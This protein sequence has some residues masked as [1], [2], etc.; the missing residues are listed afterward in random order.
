M[1]KR[2]SPQLDG[3]ARAD[4]L[5]QRRRSDVETPLRQWLGD[6]QLTDEE[7]LELVCVDILART[8]PAL[9][10]D[11]AAYFSDFPALADDPEAVLD[12]IDADI[13]ARRD[14]QLAIQ[15]EDY[16][17]RFPA[18]AARIARLIEI[19]TLESCWDDGT[20]F[21]FDQIGG[22]AQ[23]GGELSGDGAGSDG[24]SGDFSRYCS[25]EL[26]AD[27]RI[28]GLLALRDEVSCL[29]GSSAGNRSVVIKVVSKRRL[30]NDAL[31]AR[32]GD[33]LQRLSG[34]SHP[35][36]ISPDVIAE[37][38]S[39][40]VM[41]RPWVAGT[42]FTNRYLHNSPPRAE[43]SSAA[44]PL[45]LSPLLRELADLGY[46]LAAVH[47][48]GLAH[49]AVHP[50]NLLRDHTGSLRIVDAGFGFPDPGLQWDWQ[51]P[52]APLV[53]AVDA[54]HHA[55]QVHDAASLR[56][57]VA[58]ALVPYVGAGEAPLD[59]PLDTPLHQLIRWCEGTSQ[60]ARPK[61][62]VSQIADNLL[63]LADG[64]PLKL[65]AGAETA[66]RFWWTKRLGRRR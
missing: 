37:N 34:V 24:A 45:G 43:Q 53:D 40:L 21:S 4:W 52:A 36:W 39:Q 31:S 33:Y 1:T 49:G 7:I 38:A 2:I 16:S 6:Y 50:H 63:A 58:G 65:L 61:G 26:P 29:R 25:V 56:R 60:A 14:H 44:P 12:V 13:C 23:R 5:R 28:T 10:V 41:V 48:Q 59:T 46:A 8:R 66:R 3:A 42:L 11:W 9:P 47:D 35:A 32:I 62:D 64:R 57:V 17:G 30:A 22:P 15:P 51:L 55:G 27:V 20:D 19:D 18:L 54:G